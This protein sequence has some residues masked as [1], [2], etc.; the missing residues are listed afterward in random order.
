MSGI[1]S[2][3]RHGVTRRKALRGLA[4]FLAASPLL[5]AQQDHFRDHSRVPAMEELVDPTATGPLPI[6][7]A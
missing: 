7:S 4:G 5:H 2:R 3:W 1:E 6:T